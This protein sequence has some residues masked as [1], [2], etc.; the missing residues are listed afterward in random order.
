[1]NE[2][3]KKWYW[4][5]KMPV[6]A[7]TNNFEIEQFQNWTISS[8]IIFNGFSI[9][10]MCSQFQWSRT[11]AATGISP[12]QKSVQGTLPSL[13]RICWSGDYHKWYSHCHRALK[14][15]GTV[16]RICSGTPFPLLHHINI[17][18]HR[19]KCHKQSNFCSYLN[20]PFPC[21]YRKESIP[22]SRR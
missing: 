16:N 10:L 14:F 7:H 5:A 3:Q 4:F 13:H 9:D 11:L 2:L 12:L 22:Q 15:K 20:C 19:V 18:Q 1:M 17:C 8:R 21:S 6:I